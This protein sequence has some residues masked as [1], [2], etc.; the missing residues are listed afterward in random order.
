MPGEPAAVAEGSTAR[1]PGREAKCHKCTWDLVGKTELE[2]D[3]P[4][5]PSGPIG[6]FEAFPEGR[7]NGLQLPKR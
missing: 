3:T 4:V 2:E 6:W 1:D 5:R 7:R